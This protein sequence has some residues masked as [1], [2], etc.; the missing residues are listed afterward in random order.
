MEAWGA[1]A[2]G[3]AE[4]GSQLTTMYYMTLETCG[5]GVQPSNALLKTDS[6]V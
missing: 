3:Y 2:H 1:P 6:L 5:S 4:R